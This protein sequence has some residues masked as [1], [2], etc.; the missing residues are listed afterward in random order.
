MF[1]IEAKNLKFIENIVYP[2]IYIEKNKV[3]FI[4]GESGCGKT[5]LLKIFNRTAP[6]TQ[7]SV[8]FNG[9]DIKKYDPVNLRRKIILAGQYPFI[10]SESIKLAFTKIY[11][12]RKEYPPSDEKISHFLSICNISL[13]LDYP[14]SNL[15]GGE[16]QR[17]FL[18]AA[19]SLN[20]EVIL[21]D[22]P[23]SALDDDNGEAVISN[24][25]DFCKLKCI[26]AVIVSHNKAFA[27]KYSDN[28]INLKRSY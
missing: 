17:V 2:D 24:I 3:T 23:T 11:G 18:A 25:C 19:L 13:P 22:E 10:F 9:K 27:E 26:T 28:I 5:T 12:F 6:F 16:R 15:S 1:I 8:L 21:L 20:P 7:G 4:T 14:C